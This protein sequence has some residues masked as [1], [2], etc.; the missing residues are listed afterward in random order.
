METMTQSATVIDF[1]RFGQC[2]YAD[3]DVIAFPWGIPGFSQHHRWLALTLESQPGFVWLQSLDDVAVA[4]PAA[5]PWAI[6]ES[7]EPKIPAYAYLSLEVQEPSD[8]TLLCIVVARPGGEPM[9][10]NLAA[11]VVVNLKSRKARQVLC[12]SSAYSSGEPIPRRAE[13]AFSAQE[14]A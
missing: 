4:L 3:S 12:E 10:M 2:S 8:F 1:P 6:F 7:Y 11:P 9:T 14:C 13:A 5:N